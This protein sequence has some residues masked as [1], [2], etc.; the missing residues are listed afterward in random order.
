MANWATFLEHFPSFVSLCACLDKV[1]QAMILVLQTNWTQLLYSKIET[2]KLFFCGNILGICFGHILKRWFPSFSYSY[3]TLHVFTEKK[4][5]FLSPKSTPETELLQLWHFFFPSNSSRTRKFLR[6]FTMNNRRQLTT[7]EP[8]LWRR[9][10]NEMEKKI[11]T[12]TSHH[13]R[14]ATP[15]K[16]MKKNVCFQIL[17]C[18]DFYFI[19]FLWNWAWIL[20]CVCCG[21]RAK[22]HRKTHKRSDEKEKNWLCGVI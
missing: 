22:E 18:S 11:P 16:V 8:E 12:A 13:A 6:L 15:E 3:S 17:F 19:F 7:A 1:I 5:R 20:F 14:E 4:R 2:K 10:C 9:F 21:A